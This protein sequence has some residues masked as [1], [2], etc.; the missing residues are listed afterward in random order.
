MATTNKFNPPS[1]T[2]AQ[3]QGTSTQQNPTP[4]GQS[5]NL[6]QTREMAT[7]EME[8]LGKT[9]GNWGK[10][11]EV[12]APALNVKDS[13]EVIV[14]LKS[15][16]YLVPE[17]LEPDKIDKID[18]SVVSRGVE[19]EFIVYPFNSGKLGKK[20]NYSI[21]TFGESAKTIEL[22]QI[23]NKNEYALVTDKQSPEVKVKPEIP[24]Q[25]TDLPG[26]V[27]V[28]IEPKVKQEPLINE[29]EKLDLWKGKPYSNFLWGMGLK[30]AQVAS[31]G[32]CLF[33]AM[34]RL[35]RE[36]G[37]EVEIKDMLQKANKY[38]D[39]NTDIKELA[40]T[41]KYTVNGDS[42]D[43]V[44]MFQFWEEE[45]RKGVGN[46]MP[47]LDAVRWPNSDIVVGVLAEAIG[48]RV[49]VVVQ[50][51]VDGT[52]RTVGGIYGSNTEARVQYIYNRENIHYDAL[53]PK[54]SAPEPL[55]SNVLGSETPPLNEP[56]ANQQVYEEQGFGHQPESQEP[57]SPLSFNFGPSEP[58]YT[59][60]PLSKKPPPQNI[61]LREPKF[62]EVTPGN[63]VVSVENRIKNFDSIKP[64]MQKTNGYTEF[65]G[66]L[67]HSMKDKETMFWQY[68]VHNTKVLEYV[69]VFF[70]GLELPRLYETAI[71]PVTP[72]ELVKQTM[73]YNLKKVNGGLVQELRES[74]IA[75]F[76]DESEFAKY[77]KDRTVYYVISYRVS[78]PLVWII[79][80]T[81]G[82]SV[83][84][85][86]DTSTATLRQPSIEKKPR[87]LM[88]SRV[89]HRE[90]VYEYWF[91]AAELAKPMKK[92]E[93]PFIP[94][95][96]TEMTPAPMET[97]N[98]AKKRVLPNR[99]VE[100]VI[101]LPVVELEEVADLT[102]VLKNLSE[103][104]EKD[105]QLLNKIKEETTQE[106]LQLQLK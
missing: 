6:S 64:K 68:V 98:P 23:D 8:K 16:V 77:F 27:E 26:D 47:V 49:F 75:D 43:T 22:I 53:V 19:R 51:H 44:K 3:S 40:K 105:K 10:L 18:I 103:D 89:P 25:S 1:S 57:F 95:P 90:N 45:S 5:S 99:K 2:S 83:I 32:W 72:E 24:E 87:Y 80:I 55:P 11:L 62:A 29:K 37:K 88:V 78:Y 76:D 100:A 70:G 94:P 81:D 20:V 21:F 38:L 13:N 102:E 84:Y 31:D 92:E 12:I 74:R 54:T 91:G 52:V 30:Y 93:P 56:P 48:I 46:K 58:P 39:E 9:V 41:V 4:T 63:L 73:E 15:N 97:Q 101:S 14:R 79:D 7:K 42:V 17:Q 59:T 82:E 104:A 61:P 65:I 60:E 36:D 28:K 69:C 50:S 67:A 66:S 34:Q 35:S 71:D 106:K 33:H 85:V 96:V 86:I